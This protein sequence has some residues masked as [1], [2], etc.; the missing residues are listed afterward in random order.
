MYWIVYKDRFYKIF[1]YNSK[2]EIQI[3]L[4]IQEQSIK[5]LTV[6]YGRQWYAPDTNS[7]GYR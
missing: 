6:Y 5:S 1:F 3:Q 7:A 2:F 4:E